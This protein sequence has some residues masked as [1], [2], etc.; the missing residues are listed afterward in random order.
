MKISYDH[1]SG[2]G[3]KWHVTHAPDYGKRVKIVVVLDRSGSMQVIRDKTIDGYNE[4]LSGLRADTET[5]Y[6]VSLYQ[7]DANGSTPELTVTYENRKLK[8]A[9]N[10][11]RASYQPRGGTPLYDAIGECITIASSTADSEMTGDAPVVFVV[12]TD[13]QETSSRD[14]DK[15]KV[16]AL[17][18]TKTALGWTFTFLGTGIDSYSEASAMGMGAGS[19]SNYNSSLTSNMFRGLADSTIT[20]SSGYRSMGMHA[21]SVDFLNSSVKCSMGDTPPSTQG[22]TITV[23]TISAM[24]AQSFIDHIA[25]N[26]LCGSYTPTST[27]LTPDQVAEKLQLDRRTVYNKLKSGEL[28][29]T[30]VGDSWRIKSEDLP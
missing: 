19:T 22:N 25:A 29:G 11:T 21:N 14:F 27:Y 28:K 8:D 7:F 18:E 13:G 23:G 6:W 2:R 20:R 17:I 30:K 15:K 9:H 10:L 1:T 24:D 12:I 5:E 4:Y 26:P 16:K 3:P